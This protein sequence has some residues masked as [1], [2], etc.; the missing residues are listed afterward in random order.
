MLHLLPHNLQLANANVFSSLSFLI[1]FHNALFIGDNTEG[2]DTYKK[3]LMKENFVELV[4][5]AGVEYMD[6]VIEFAKEYNNE[7][8][9]VIIFSEK[10]LC[11]NACAEIFNLAMTTGKLGK[12]A[13]GLMSIKEKN[14][15]QGIFD[16]GICPTLGVG[17]I[18]IKDKD[19][20]AAMKKV[21]KVKSPSTSLLNFLFPHRCPAAIFVGYLTEF[22]R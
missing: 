9:A 7:M 10:E 3:D 15:A 19:L 11:S 14:N 4:E 21:W 1:S 13:N 17:A 12:T 2:F 16:M 6:S 20:Q 22:T 18:D 5:A 8:N